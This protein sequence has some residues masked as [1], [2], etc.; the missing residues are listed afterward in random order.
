MTV[1][2]PT[3]PPRASAAH[4]PAFK[5][6]FKFERESIE[7]VSKTGAWAAYVFVTNAGAGEDEI[8]RR[9]GCTNQLR[10]I[11]GAT[12]TYAPAQAGFYCAFATDED[13]AFALACLAYHARPEQPA[14]PRLRLAHPERANTTIP[15]PVAGCSE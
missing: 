10:Y 6:P 4:H 14:D 12:S 1:Q 15:C 8:A 3:D 5:G 11:L 7:A 2:R 13:D 9:F